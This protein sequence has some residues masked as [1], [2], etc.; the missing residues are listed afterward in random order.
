M[1]VMG[2]DFWRYGVHEKQGRDRSPGRDTAF[3]AGPGSIASLLRKKL[4]A[5]SV[6]RI[7]EGVRG[8]GVA[9]M[10]RR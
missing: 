6:F 3:R 7:V 5:P 8:N 10:E 1:A 2:D 4:F 9:W